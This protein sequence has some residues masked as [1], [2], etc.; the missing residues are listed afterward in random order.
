[1]KSS[2]NPISLFHLLPNPP[3]SS[4]E[5]DDFADLDNGMEALLKGVP[6]NF[7]AYNDQNISQLGFGFWGIWKWA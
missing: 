5:D 1:M 6:M 7:S 2:Q 3:P 4:N